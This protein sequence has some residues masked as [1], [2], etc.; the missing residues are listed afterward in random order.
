MDNSAAAAAFAAPVEELVVYG[1]EGGSRAVSLAS[2]SVSLGRA[3]SNDLSYPD[4]SG[5]SRQHFVIERVGADFILKDLGSKNG[6]ELN[7][8]RVSGSSM[9]RPG[10]RIKAGRLT[11]EFRTSGAKTASHT[12]LF[13]EAPSIDTSSRTHIGS[14]AV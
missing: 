5:L 10:D 4:D 1:P 12:V 9:L 13:V 3:A 7:S 2:G 8:R 11:I 6:T 14:S